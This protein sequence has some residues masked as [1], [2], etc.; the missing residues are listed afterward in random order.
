MQQLNQLQKIPSQLLLQT[1]KCNIMYSQIYEVLLRKPISCCTGKEKC[2]SLVPR[3][4]TSLVMYN[5]EGQ[6]RNALLSMKTT[7]V[8]ISCL[9]IQVIPFYL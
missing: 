2:T 6:L 5:C 4:K 1:L 9:L 7:G 3:A 8:I